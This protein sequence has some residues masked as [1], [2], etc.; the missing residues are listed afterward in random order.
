MLG[1]N[2]FKNLA[3]PLILLLAVSWAAWAQTRQDERDAARS[4]TTSFSKIRN[5]ALDA[6]L[7]ICVNDGGVESCR[8]TV[9]GPTDTI[10][11]GVGSNANVNLGSLNGTVD[12]SEISYLNGVTSSIQTQLSGKQATITGAASTITGS[13]LTASRAL[14][15]D[16]SGK[17]GVS[18]VTSTELGY[19]DTVT[20]NVQT[21]LNGKQAT[22]TGGATTI[23][24]SNLTASRALVSDGS[25]KVAVSAVTSTELGYVDGV[26][27]AIQTQLNGKQATIATS[28]DNRLTRYNGTSNV[29]GTGIT[30]SDSDGL[31]GVNSILMDSG[32][33]ITGMQANKDSGNGTCTPTNGTT[34]SCSYSDMRYI[35]MNNAVM[36]SWDFDYTTGS[37]GGTGCRCP[38][39]IASSFTTGNDLHGTCAGIRSTAFQYGYVTANTA[40]NQLNITMTNT[41]AGTGFLKCV[42]MYQIN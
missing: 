2:L 16:G 5:T 38:I 4:A 17:V 36:I 40:N 30:V 19:L 15:S 26:T 39:P 12:A 18:A 33:T 10:D 3:G 7:Q 14:I 29:Q 13:N 23:A 9:D 32:G 8:I 34:S 1:S 41:S 22:I 35:M 11:L 31:S 20:S 21:Q 24:S 25:G 6:D 28:A 27:S 42:A 37:T